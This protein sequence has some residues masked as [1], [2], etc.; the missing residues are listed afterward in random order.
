MNREIFTSLD[1]ARSN[2]AM[3]RNEARLSRG[4]DGV[5]TID[6]LRALTS[7]GRKR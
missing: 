3:L 4:H 5:A 1:V 6:R 2:V 7:L